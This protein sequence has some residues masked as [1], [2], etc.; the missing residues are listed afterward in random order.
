MI[1]NN[2]DTKILTKF[3]KS[4]IKKSNLSGD[5]KIEEYDI[6]RIYLWSDGTEY[7]IRMWNYFQNGIVN[8]TLF[9]DIDDGDGT[10]RGE[11][12]CEGENKI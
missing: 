7:T 10:G 6:D 12:I 9:R 1:I 5:F 11:E 8:W 4:V 3:V 2:T